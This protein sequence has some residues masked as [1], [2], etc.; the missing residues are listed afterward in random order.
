MERSPGLARFA[1]AAILALAALAASAGTGVAH[2]QRQ[3]NDYYAPDRDRSLLWNVEQYHMGL[4]EE[5]MA[6][7]RWP[8]AMQDI[9]FILR[10][11]P[12]HPRALLL[13]VKACEAWRSATCEI[14]RYFERA[15]AVNPN[16]STTYVVQGITLLRQG[17]S[18]PAI[19]ALEKA[20]ALDPRSLNAQYNLALGYL[21][22][23]DYARAN[24]HAQ[25]AYAL[26][27]PLPGLRDRLQ[28]AGQWRP[29]AV[30]KAGPDV[31]APAAPGAG[32]GT[33]AVPAAAPAGGAAPSSTASRPAP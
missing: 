16:V 2:A 20:V 11:Y 5:K 28:R 4:A 9:D 17:R 22:R 12:N 14:D 29:E 7:R 23:K 25:V 32:T 26:G 31:A 8:Q 19:A 3:N 15:V 6:D 10:Y 27:A 18:D 33:Q 1:R 21:D 30:A 24:E 13:M